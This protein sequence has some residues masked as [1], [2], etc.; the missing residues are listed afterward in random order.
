MKELYKMTCH[1]PT[2]LVQFL[3]NFQQG[4]L[5]IALSCREVCCT[6][7]HLITL[8]DIDYTEAMVSV[9]KQRERTVL[10]WMTENRFYFQPSPVAVA[11]ALHV[12]STTK[13]IWNLMVN[14]SKEL[15]LELQKALQANRRGKVLSQ[16]YR[17]TPSLPRKQRIVWA[18]SYGMLKW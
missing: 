9:I 14:Y 3:L 1:F 10:Q 4:D 5:L 12:K 2:E 15:D 16:F 7:Y 13:F 8:P 17:S 6:W 18:G 11:L